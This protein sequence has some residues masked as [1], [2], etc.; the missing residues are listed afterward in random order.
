MQV[1]HHNE[2]LHVAGYTVN[3]SM[4]YNAKMNDG[5]SGPDLREE[6]IELREKVAALEER[7]EGRD[8]VQKERTGREQAELRGGLQD[9]ITELKTTIKTLG[10]VF[11]ILLTIISLVIALFRAGIV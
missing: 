8:S 7:L 5:T 6:I 1:F 4:A 3:V 10:W 11:G 2:D 9:Q